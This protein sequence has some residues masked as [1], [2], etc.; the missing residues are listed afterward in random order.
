MLQEYAPTSLEITGGAAS[1]FRQSENVAVIADDAATAIE[2]RL[3]TLAQNSDNEQV[4]LIGGWLPSALQCIPPTKRADRIVMARGMA[5]VAAAAGLPIMPELLKALWLKWASRKARFDAEQDCGGL[6][7]AVG[8]EAAE[9]AIAAMCALG[10]KCGAASVLGRMEEELTAEQEGA[11]EARSTI[12]LATGRA[13]IKALLPSLHTD[14]VAKAT[15]YNVPIEAVSLGILAVAASCLTPGTGLRQK[16][17]WLV[18]PCI[19]AC[20]LGEVS[21][22]KSPT[23]R[24]ATAPLK[25]I[26]AD[27]R[28]SYNAA[29]KAYKKQLR[30]IDK[31]DG[32]P[33]DAGDAPILSLVE[34]AD[35]TREAVSKQMAE[36]PHRGFVI[37]VD[38]LKGWLLS[39][40]QYRRGGAGQADRAY[41]LTAY[42]GGAIPKKRAGGD[43]E[44]PGAALAPVFGGIQ[45]SVLEALMQSDPADGM[46]ARFLW[47]GV[48]DG[49]LPKPGTVP[50]VNMAPRLQAIYEGLPLLG[51]R[52]YALSAEA[53]ALW[54]DWHEAVEDARMAASDPAVRGMWP[55]TREHALRI[56]LI[57]HLIEAAANNCTPSATIAGATLEAA[58]TFAKYSLGQALAGFGGD[59]ETRKLLEFA[60]K[61]SGETIEWRAAQRAASPKASG[62]GN[63]DQCIAFLRSVVDAGLATCIIPG[64]YSRIA[65]QAGL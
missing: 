5:A 17:D 11:A 6:W 7:C 35:L 44:L 13:D 15:E 40:D 38:E 49:R 20:L 63:R 52:E 54:V 18:S 45:P 57:A 4:R 19:Y 42:D 9:E 29:L 64:D 50:E 39:F 58:I 1:E 27:L 8:A 10:T 21:A 23:M 55:K 3:T 46:W 48:P 43:A 62:R 34:L 24:V 37:A 31:A 16:A 30:A 22:L 65:V 32:D 28:A 59:A 2:A 47:A 41:W 56:A 25:P 60:V 51:R 33:D 53:W 26:Q 36:Q 14:L 61:R 12:A